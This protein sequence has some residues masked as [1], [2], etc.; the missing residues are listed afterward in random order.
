M[1][2]YGAFC[3]RV[4]KETRLISI[5]WQLVYLKQK[6]DNIAPRRK[7]LWKK[8]HESAFKSYV[9]AHVLS[10]HLRKSPYKGVHVDSFIGKRAKHLI[11]SRA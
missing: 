7:A 4:V 8:M 2:V 11:F 3:Q 1:Q 5:R 9:L 6:A 10:V